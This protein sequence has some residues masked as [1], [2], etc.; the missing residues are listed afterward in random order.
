MKVSDCMTRDVRVAAPT[1]S[2]R[3]AAR[4]M[5]ELDVVILP[6]GENDRLVGMVTDPDIAVRGVA[7][8]FSWKA[9]R[10]IRTTIPTMICPAGPRLRRAC[11]GTACGPSG[12]ASA[13]APTACP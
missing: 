2:L 13:S 10:S 12:A 11:I 3:E 4:L 5:A 1:Q 7:Q 8:G 9:A 6:V